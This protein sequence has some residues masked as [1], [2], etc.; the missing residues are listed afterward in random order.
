VRLLR[1]IRRGRRRGFTLPRRRRQRFI[2]HQA[3]VQVRIHQTQRYVRVAH[4]T[5]RRR[6]RR[7][8]R[9]DTVVLIAL[10]LT[11]QQRHHVITTVVVVF[12]TVVVVTSSG[13]LSSRWLLSLLSNATTARRRR[14]RRRI[15]AMKRRIQHLPTRILK[16]PH[17]VLQRLIRNQITLQRTLPTLRTLAHHRQRPS[18]AIATKRMRAR[19]KAHRHGEQVAANRAS[20]ARIER[21]LRGRGPRLGHVHAVTTARVCPLRERSKFLPITFAM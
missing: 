4:R 3:R 19:A 2:L 7:R 11:E 12:I 10:A 17:R 18:Y 20:H 15:A 1:A 6:R 9:L 13:I 8:R 5:R 16:T 14:R 21:A